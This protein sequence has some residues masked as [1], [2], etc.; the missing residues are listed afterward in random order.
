MNLAT[1]KESFGQRRKGTKEKCHAFFLIR[2]F[3]PLWQ[4]FFAAKRRKKYFLL[5]I[6]I[7]KELK[8]FYVCLRLTRRQA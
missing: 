8:F 3:E 2:A 5:F 7:I 1:P 4:P 6:V